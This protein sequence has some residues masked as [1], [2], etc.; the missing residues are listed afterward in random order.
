MTVITETDVIIVGSGVAGLT[1]AI[2][3]AKAGL[4]VL[5]VEKTKYFGGTTAFSGGAPWI[6][7]N[8]HMKKLGLE[9]SRESAVEYIRNCLGDLYDADKVDIF[10]DNAP[11]MLKF[12]ESNSEVRF[13][14]TTMPD[15]VP[16]QSG[17]RNGR[18]LL[19]E[20]YDGAR[21]G[22]HLKDL[23]PPLNELAVFGSMQIESADYHPLRKA[24]TTVS[25]FKHS[26]R[27]ISRFLLSRIRH[28]RG[29]RIANGNALVAR[30]LRSALDDRNITLW[31]NSP[32]R[33]L[34]QENGEVHGLLVEVDGQQ[35]SIR[36]RKAVVLASG[37]FGANNE[38]RARFV[39]MAEHHWSLQPEGNVGDGI[40]MGEAVGGVLNDTNPDNCIW[41]PV[42]VMRTRDDKVIKFPHL[43]FD[44]Y[45]PGAIAVDPCG[46][47]F[48]DENAS[49]QTFVST[50]HDRGLHQ[51]YLIA[52]HQFLR[53]YG[54]GLVRPAPFPYRRFV[55]NGYLIE[56]QS[57]SGLAAKIR[58]DSKTLEQTV[59]N[60]NQYA[61]NGI[62]PEFGSGGN[63]YS[64]FTGDHAH[65][66]NPALGPCAKAP[67]YAVAI[68]PGDLSTICGLNTNGRAQVLSGNG[69][70]INGLYAIGLDMNSTFRGLYIGGGSSIGPAMTYAYVAANTIAAVESLA[71]YS[72]ASSTRGGRV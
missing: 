53:S 1:A 60:F 31:K 16:E 15:Y 11:R 29:T 69:E 12:M 54:L 63:P 46:K 10:L 26:T 71:S 35:L 8:H 51:A 58:A 55:Q 23:R 40:K 24:L 14:P 42:S 61:E 52:D 33:R 59:S 57:I 7:C 22:E 27:L 9:D 44:R 32:A 56:A 30:L 28:G 17:W 37:G 45:M 70:P 50:M 34:I 38:M 19:T 5:V 68:H 67:F 36:A 65:K 13:K 21:L 18:T 3:A 47:R 25:G 6:P 41:V 43:R 49:Y 62:D 4:N 39:P 66:P 20:E 48:V 64:R 2:V 72:S